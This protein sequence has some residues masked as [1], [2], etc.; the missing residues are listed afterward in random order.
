VEQK[1]GRE[2]EKME[3]G[4]MQRRRKKKKRGVWGIAVWYPVVLSLN[5]DGHNSPT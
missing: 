4:R 1:V 5:P 2:K 3:E